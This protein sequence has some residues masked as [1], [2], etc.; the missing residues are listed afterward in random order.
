MGGLSAAYFIDPVLVAAALKIGLDEDLHHLPRLL[1][2]RKTG[3]YT[4][5]IGIVVLA[6]QAGHI[7]LK[8]EA[9]P[10]A[11]VLIGRHTNAVGAA[12]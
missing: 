10:D 3:R 8:A 11:L 12:A 1:K 4:D 5:D 6:D 7:R 2:S 9:C